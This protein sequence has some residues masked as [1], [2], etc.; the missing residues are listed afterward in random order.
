MPIDVICVAFQVLP[1]FDRRREP[2]RSFIPSNGG[3]VLILSHCAVNLTFGD[4]P[5]DMSFAE[6]FAVPIM[7]YPRDFIQPHWEGYIKQPHCV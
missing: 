3:N 5:T 4:S 2:G 6:K 7:S 1:D